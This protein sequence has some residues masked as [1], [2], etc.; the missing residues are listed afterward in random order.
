MFLKYGIAPAVA[1]ALASPVGV[2][3]Q[4]G[5]Q[6]QSQ[7][8]QAEQ[9]EARQHEVIRADELIGQAVRDQKNERIGRVENLALNLENGR[10]VYAVVSRGGVWGVGGEEVAVE[11]KQ[12]RPDA[13]SRS[14][15]IEE[16]QLQQ[17]RRIETG[18]AWPADIGEDRPVGTT[19][20]T[21][22][23]GR[24]VVP[25]D[26]LLGMD[27]QNK[28]GENLGRIDDVAIGRNGAVS[29]AVI[30]YGG[31]LGMDDKYTAVPWDRLD[32]NAEREAVVLDVTREQ[33]ENARAFEYRGT[34]PGKVEW[35][36]GSKR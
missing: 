30:A 8:Q 3:A 32:V 29:Y 28:Q 35:P 4:A 25:I 21:E 19:G 27:V 22:A 15:H 9:R 24:R 36:F 26:N 14:V 12:L 16:Q 7:P 23:S 6:P 5:Q 10:I 17:A 2:A 18:K 1:L 31:F 11:W 13:A 34:W 33:L 20:A